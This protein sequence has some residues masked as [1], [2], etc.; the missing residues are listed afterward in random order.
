MKD[1]T[2]YAD[3]PKTLI[4]GTKTGFTVTYLDSEL[5][6][7][8]ENDG[9]FTSDDGG[10]T[11]AHNDTTDPQQ[12][13][14]QTRI[15]TDA[16]DNRTV[17]ITPSS[18][19]DMSAMIGQNYGFIMFDLNLSSI[20][21][22]P[23]IYSIGFID[24]QGAPVTD[25]IAYAGAHHFRI[26]ATGWHRVFLGLNMFQ[27]LGTTLDTADIDKVFFAFHDT[28]SRTIDFDRMRIGVL[29]EFP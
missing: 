8:T 6:W 11:I 4:T 29:A 7:E 20:A 9:N 12:G 3:D 25:Y 17:T 14:Y 18:N 10:D 24:G 15:T 2:G 22:T 13:S 5:D 26:D 16:S 27:I 23:Y 19:K 21:D 28:A 1:K